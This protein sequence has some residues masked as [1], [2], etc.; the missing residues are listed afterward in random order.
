MTLGLSKPFIICLFISIAIGY[1]THNWV[2]IIALVLF[3]GTLTII[4]RFL[5]R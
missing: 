2:T 5:T 3:F 4:W 1:A